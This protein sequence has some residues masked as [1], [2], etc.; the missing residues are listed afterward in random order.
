[1]EVENNDA[2]L[3]PGQCI[4]PPGNK[5]IAT[6]LLKELYNLTAL[7]V[8]DL[9]AYD[10]RNY[11]VICDG[12]HTNPHI[13]NISECGYVLK[14]V[15]SLDS[16]KEHV[17]EAQTDMLIFLNKRE[18][19][20]PLPVKNV[21]G[22]YHTLVE[23]NADGCTGDYVVRL[24]VYRPGELLRHVPITGELLRNVGSFT[25]KLSNV[26]LN[27]SH[28]AYN[29]HKTM[30]MLNSVPKLRQFTYAVKNAL[31]RELAHQ[32]I[33]AFEKEVL[34][35]DLRLEHGMIHGDLNEQNLVVSS[36]GREI[37]AVIDFGDSHRTSL[38]F[39]LAITLCYMILQAGD[40]AMGK[41]VIEG[42]QDIR[43]LTEPEKKILK[44]T[45]CARLCQSLVMGAYSHLYDP[46]NDYLLST[47]KSGWTLLKK[48]WPLSQDAILRNW[49]LTD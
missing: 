37:A 23:L 18:I 2:V 48:L 1:M 36:N 3:I 6:K 11:H 19:T 44:T 47:Q 34:E 14:I 31:E 29:E 30:W 24:L 5:E 38:I 17:I 13:T 10:D 7:S 12:S 32:V 9:N 43:K 40:I 8:T 33:L 28:S 15:N 41:H 49:G 4:R 42:Y 16:K 46:Q 20:C 25:A 22:L 45:V 21:H 26:L 35:I 27:F 39:E